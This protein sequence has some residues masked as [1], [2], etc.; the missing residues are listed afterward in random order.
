MMDALPTH[1]DPNNVE[2][3]VASATKTQARPSV[4]PDENKDQIDNGGCEEK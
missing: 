1:P 2:I 3:P 4:S